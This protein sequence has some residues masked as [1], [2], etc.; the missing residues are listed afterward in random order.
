MLSVVSV[1]FFALLLGYPIPPLRVLLLLPT[2]P[3]LLLLGSKAY[4]FLAVSLF[5]LAWGVIPVG[6]GALVLG[7]PAGRERLRK[8][9][10]V[11][12]PTLCALLCIYL[13]TYAHIRLTGG[14]T[15]T[16]EG[17]L[18][19]R[20]VDRVQFVRV[21][22]PLGLGAFFYPIAML[23]AEWLHVETPVPPCD[24]DKDCL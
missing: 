3:A 9:C 15:F 22:A 23:D 18:S 1:S 4:L 7:A 10:A 24:P 16:S 8:T 6:I 12:A 5:L 20:G 13:I 19:N 2:L 11:V 14:V 21:D 17:F